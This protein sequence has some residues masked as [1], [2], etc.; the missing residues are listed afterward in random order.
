MCINSK[1]NACNFFNNFKKQLQ[2]SYK[3]AK[4][5]LKNNPTTHKTVRYDNYITEN[6]ILFSI[7]PP[8]ELVRVHGSGKQN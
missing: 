6:K 3:I 2:I 8:L 1:K 4:K 5:K 7:L